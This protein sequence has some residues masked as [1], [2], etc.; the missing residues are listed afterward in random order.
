VPPGRTRSQVRVTG[1]PVR[2]TV[3]DVRAGGN[4]EN[5]LREW[6]RRYLP[7]EIAGTIAELGG[8]AIAYQATGSLAAAAIIATIGA[9]AGYY[10]A[11]YVTAVRWSYHGS[12]RQRW[13]ARVLMSN[14]LALRSVVVEFGPAELIDSIAV[15]PIAFYVGPQIFDNTLAGWIFAKLISDL[16]FYLIAIVSYEQFKPLLVRA[17]PHTEE[18]TDEAVIEAEAA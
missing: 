18:V 2:G 5:K 11:A 8:A 12:N 9:S 7:C 16:A 10:S 17:H 15:R 4:T 14:L 6:I 13:P 1:A 3:D